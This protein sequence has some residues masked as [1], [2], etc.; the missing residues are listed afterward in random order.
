MAKIVYRQMPAPRELSQQIPA[1]G[2]KLVCKSPRV[3]AN[4]WCKSSGVR[5]VW[6]KLISAW[7]YQIFNNAVP[8]LECSLYSVCH[9]KNVLCKIPVDS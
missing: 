7:P 8:F 9:I 4:F 2:Q 1:P 3:G 5:G 6:M